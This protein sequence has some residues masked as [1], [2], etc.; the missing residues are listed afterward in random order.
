MKKSPA[1]PKKIS[2][3]QLSAASEIAYG[4][5]GYFSSSGS[6]SSTSTQ[7]LYGSINCTKT[8]PSITY[9]PGTPAESEELKRES[10]IHFLIEKIKL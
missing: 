5:S 6:G 1:I 2:A 9:I 7:G 3:S 4:S 8:G 10:M